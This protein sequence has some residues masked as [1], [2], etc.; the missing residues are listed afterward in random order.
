[1]KH[2]SNAKNA[3]LNIQDFKIINAFCNG[4][5][6]IKTLKEI[7]MKKP[8]TMTNLLAVADECIEASKARA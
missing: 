1:M 4:V 7:A 5:T 6:D 3:I 8:K 2:F